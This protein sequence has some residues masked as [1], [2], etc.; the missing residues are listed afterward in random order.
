MSNLR[1]IRFAVATVASFAFIAPP[2]CVAA[3]EPPPAP[4]VDQ[5]IAYYIKKL[6]KHPTLFAVHALLGTAYLEKARASNEPK[7][8]PLAESSLEK[9]L[10]IQPNFDAHKGMTAL[11]A[12]R[13]RFAEALRW[14][15]RAQPTREETDITALMV[16]TRLGLGEIDQAMKLLPP[17]DSEPADFYTA[18]SIAAV[19]KAQEHFD[20]A[21][22]AYLQAEQF[23]Q[24]QGATGVAV[25]ARTNAAG[26]LIDSGQV[27]KAR[28]DLDAAT[29]LQ[30]DNPELRLHWAEYYAAQGEPAQA[31]EV[32]ESLL[33]E[34]PHP[35]YHHRA[36]LLARKLGNKAAAKR[37]YTAAE[38]GYRLPLKTKEIYTLGSLAQLYC[39]ADTH[40]DKAR[41]LARRNLKYKRDK[42]AKDAL[43]CV[44]G[45]LAKKK[46]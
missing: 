18:A 30:K 20:E 11:N 13:H 21:R 38:Q 46:N 27:A 9:S 29:L 33:K 42:E 15:E 34:L 7:W 43:A 44:D 12:F 28:A 23:A 16:E 24:E 26:M 6:E 40:L 39:D 37:H 41:S 5:R 22:A 25:W 45:K 31:Y 17:L 19:L 36:Y 2:V 10:K 35:V 14:A 3:S 1:V 4:T 32:L 8:L